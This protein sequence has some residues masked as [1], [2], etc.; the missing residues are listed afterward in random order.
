MGYREDVAVAIEVEG[1]N[2]LLSFIKAWDQT[3]PE[4]SQSVV[5]LIEAGVDEHHV[6][7]DGDHLLIF[8]S[9]KTSADD[10]EAFLELLQNGTIRGNGGVDYDKWLIRSVGECGEE[11]TYGDWFDNPFNIGI[12][13]NLN[14]DA[15]G[16]DYQSGPIIPGRANPTTKPVAPAVVIKKVAGPPINNHTCT[17][18]GNAAC[19]KDEKSCWKCGCPISSS[20]TDSYS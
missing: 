11:E 16:T 10:Y 4:K 12:T 5:E 17:Q 1:W 2:Q 19:S 6:N 3:A 14:F 18:C 8:T 20:S 7:D 9:I 15:D 13:H